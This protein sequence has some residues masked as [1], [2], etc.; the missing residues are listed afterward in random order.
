MKLN[1]GWTTTGLL[2][3]GGLIRVCRK[4]AGRFFRIQSTT[5]YLKSVEI[6][7]DL[8]LYQLGILICAVF[9]VFGVILIQVAAIFYLPLSQETK[10]GVCLFV[11][12]FDFM[13]ALGTLLYLSSSSRWLRQ[14]K[15][16]D[17][18]LEEFLDQTQDLYE[19]RHPRGAQKAREP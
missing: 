2:A 15:K 14:A 11:G 5:L 1:P 7:R 19:H 10:V 8:F 18:F 9:L 3:A 17:K 16:Y 4:S 6:V 12:L 13:A